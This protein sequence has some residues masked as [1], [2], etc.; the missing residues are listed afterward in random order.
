MIGNISQFGV[1]L[2][3]SRISKV[4]LMQCNIWTTYLSPLVTTDLAA[5]HE[6]QDQ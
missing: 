3:K 2:I 4:T 6:Y 1:Y 5:I